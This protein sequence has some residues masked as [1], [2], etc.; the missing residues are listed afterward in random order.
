MGR[1]F[2]IHMAVAVTSITF[3]PLAMTSSY[4]MSWNFLALG[5]FS[6]S[7]VYTPSTRVPFS[8]TSASIS[9]PR[10]DDPVSVVKYGLPVPALKMTTSPCSIAS[11]ARHLL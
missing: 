4:V 7:A 11:I 6:G 3:R 8:I 1:S 9:M 2:C 5:S 10:S